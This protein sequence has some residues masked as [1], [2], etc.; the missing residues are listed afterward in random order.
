M[1]ANNSS[2]TSNITTKALPTNCSAS[3]PTDIRAI[4][5]NA[6]MYEIDFTPIFRIGEDYT[7]LMEYYDLTLDIPN[8]TK[9]Q[10]L[11]NSDKYVNFLKTIPS[12]HTFK[13]RI[14][15]NNEC[16]NGVFSDWQTVLP[17]GSLSHCE[18]VNYPSNLIVSSACSY[19]GG[20]CGTANFQWDPVSG[21][22]LYEVQYM[23]LNYAVGSPQP[24]NGSFQTTLAYYTSYNMYVNYNLQPWRINFRVRTKC[25]DGSW[26]DYSPWSANFAW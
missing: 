14:K 11:Y 10:T 20:V 12:M 13:F 9:T 22:T 5:I 23:M 21:A 25:Q 18:L 17:Q 24:I 3:S 15:V 16:E 26:S 19:P 4:S 1:F 6:E 7:Y 8:S 2:T